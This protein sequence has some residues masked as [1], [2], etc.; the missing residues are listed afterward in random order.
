MSTIVKFFDNLL[1]GTGKTI[2]GLGN[3]LILAPA[4]I[5]FSGL[6]YAFSAYEDQHPS[7][8]TETVQQ[9]PAAPSA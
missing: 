8:I 2:E 9:E 3:L 6:V 1:G 4:L 7:A 5:V